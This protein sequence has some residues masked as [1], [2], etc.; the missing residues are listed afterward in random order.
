MPRRD[1][2]TDS[3]AEK[4]AGAPSGPPQKRNSPLASD[5]PELFRDAVPNIILRGVRATALALLLCAVAFLEQIAE[6]AAPLLLACGLGWW[7]LPHLLGLAASGDGQA[8]EMLGQILAS[9]PARLTLGGHVVSPSLL[10]AYG[11]LVMGFAAMLQ[12]A[13]ALITG[14]IC[15]DR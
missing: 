10:I 12:A 3:G 7:A 13:G 15:R 14:A 5:L 8:R 9:L 2:S 11:L 6:F 4:P 1:F